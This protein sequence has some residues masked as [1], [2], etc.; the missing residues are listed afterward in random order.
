MTKIAIPLNTTMDF[1]HYNPVTAPKF[2]IYTMDMKRK[3]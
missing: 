3:M 2:A 1:Y